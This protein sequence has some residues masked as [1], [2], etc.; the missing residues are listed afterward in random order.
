MLKQYFL[1]FWIFLSEVEEGVQKCREKS[2][3]GKF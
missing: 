1:R 3:F 2:M